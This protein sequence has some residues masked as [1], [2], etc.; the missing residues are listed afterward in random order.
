MVDDQKRDNE[1]V[2][3]EQGRSL[4]KV[5]IL[6]RT[7]LKSCRPMCS[8]S[9]RGESLETTESI[10]SLQ[11]TSVYKVERGRPVFHSDVKR[12]GT[13]TLHR[14]TER[15]RLIHT[16]LRNS[17]VTHEVGKRKMVTGGH[18]VYYR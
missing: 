13:C 12:R 4:R 15:N 7:G 9:G 6:V 10:S 16:H 17:R 14:Y 11:P 18:K 1:V 5:S 3:F 2:R 8:K